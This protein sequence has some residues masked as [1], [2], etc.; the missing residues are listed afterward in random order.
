MK[1]QVFGMLLSY[2]ALTPAAHAAVTVEQPWVRAMVPGQSV[3]AAYMKIRSSERAALVGVQ[4][5]A[6]QKVE[7]HEMSMSNGVMKMR[8]L[9][10]LDLPSERTVELTPGGYHLMLMNVTKPLKEGDEVPLTLTIE[11]QDKTRVQVE[12]QAPVRSI[13]SPGASHGRMH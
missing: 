4:T 10:R 1:P 9:T 11:R 2:L 5:P 8:P 13:T 6:A 3:A 7:I 12:V